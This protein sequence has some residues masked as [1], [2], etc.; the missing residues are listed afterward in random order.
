MWF[1]LCGEIILWS[2][3]L[4]EVLK[5]L[6]NYMFYEKDWQDFCIC[7][8]LICEIFVQDVFKFY[9]GYEIQFGVDCQIDDE[10]DDFIC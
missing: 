1:L 9:V 7:I 2:S 8:C 5:I 3:D 10:L 4:K 6:F